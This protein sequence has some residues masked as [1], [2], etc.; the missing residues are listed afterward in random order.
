M[1]LELINKKERKEKKKKKK[2]VKKKRKNKKGSNN[3]GDS[4]VKL[5]VQY[6]ACTLSD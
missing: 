5:G 3:E 1:C 6:T 2:K 4:K